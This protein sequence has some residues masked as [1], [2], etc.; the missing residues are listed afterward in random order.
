M[1]K[2]GKYLILILWMGLWDYLDNRFEIPR[3]IYYFLI[4]LPIGIGG[5]LLIFYTFEKI[6]KNKK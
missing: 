6:E 4:Y 1:R 2:S 3:N 5:V